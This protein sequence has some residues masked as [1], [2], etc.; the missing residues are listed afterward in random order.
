MDRTWIAKKGDR[1]LSSK[2]S[3]WLQRNTSPIPKQRDAF[4]SGLM[5][6]SHGADQ[7]L[8]SS[9]DVRQ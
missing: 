5:R 6:P 4:S 1:F 8:T 2:S 9:G 7:L 3:S